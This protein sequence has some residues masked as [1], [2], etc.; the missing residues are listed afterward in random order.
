MNKEIIDL[1]EEL[2]KT[3]RREQA[4]HLQYEEALSLARCAD[5]KQKQATVVISE[6]V[7]ELK[8]V[9]SARRTEKLMRKF[10]LL[11]RQS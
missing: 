10:D 8:D 9:V 1:K 6:L 4:L 3:Q 2:E 7:T 5:E 11:N